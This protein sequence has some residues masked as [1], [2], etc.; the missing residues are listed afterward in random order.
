[1]NALEI[2][3][4]AL[5]KDHSLAVSASLGACLARVGNA[6]RAPSGSPVAETRYGKV[7]GV[8]T[9]GIGIFKGIPY[10]GPTE[11]AN[12]FQPP[13]KPEK[14]SGIR[15]A[16]QT[17]PRCIQS[18][19]NL[20]DTAIGDYFCG[21]RKDQ[22]GLAQQTDSENCLV[23]NVLTP[24]LKGKRPVMVYIHGGGFTSG[25]GIIALAADAFPRDEDVVLVSVNH[26]LN[27]FAY[28]Y[29]GG[30][31]EK[32]ADSGNAGMLD[33]V[34][35]LQWVRDN[36]SSFGG[37][38]GNVT[39]FGESG[40]GG[41]VSALMAMPSAQGL[42]GKAIVE[43]G[44][45]LRAGDKEQATARAKALLTKLGIPE[46]RLE[47]LQALP[48][49]KLF[50]AAPGGS[51]IVD[52]RSI[53]NQTWDPNAP[54]I[55]AAVQMIVGTCKDESAWLIGER[56][57]STFTLD[58][59]GMRTRLV[60]SLQQPVADIAE[61]I[62]IYRKA[63]PNATPSDIFFEISSDR[64]TRMNAIAQAERKTRLGKAPAYMYYFAYDTP[65]DGGKY[66]A[67]HTAELPLV[68][69]LVRYPNSDAVS[70]QLAGAWAAFARHGNPNHRGLPFWSPYNLE[71][72]A[73]MVFAG[74]NSHQENDP[75]REARLKF[76]ALP[77]PRRGRA[78]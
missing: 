30:I 12:R 74:E 37:D 21:G 4:R 29:L 76:L 38:P 26:R 58:E 45:S 70:R 17:G 18:P 31:S 16:S 10:G 48:A 3:R 46:N 39:I 42:F 7:R 15:D 8:E 11:G 61:L 59:E 36:I 67:F 63:R 56:D 23:L 69:R 54:E 57:P 27:V 50:A 66:R 35:A 73:T 1:M 75:L 72:R 6:A 33:L 65:M 19:G 9:N 53:P 52:G 64:S 55:S 62:A 68:L 24:G 34:A 40:G 77:V 13:R 43:S 71:A 20:F 47:D 32:F 2:S 60:R 28:T 49:A 44:S 41:K 5:L 78:G 22:L 25:S 14:W 51:P